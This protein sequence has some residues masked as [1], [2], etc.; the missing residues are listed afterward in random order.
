MGQIIPVILPLYVLII[1]GY[2]SVRTRYLSAVDLVGASMLIMRVFLPAMIFLAIAARP[3]TRSFRPDF[4]LAYTVAGLLA[5]MIAFGVARLAGRGTA[6]AAIEAMG[7]SCPNSGYFGLPLTTLALGSAVATQA[8]ALAVIV[9]NMIVIPV[10]IALCDLGRRPGKGGP[11]LATFALTLIRNPLL[12]AVAAGLFWA[13]TGAGL[14][15]VAARTLEMMDP[16]AA[17]AVLVAIGGALA[18]LSPAAE[19]RG[20]ARVVIGKLILHPLLALGAVAVLAPTL[21]PPLRAALVLYAASP[22]M[23]IYTLF[24]QHYREEGVAVTAM[25]GAI[26]ASVITIPAIVWLVQ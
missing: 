20:A 24:G 5:L 21:D 1:I 11:G 6:R 19:A 10:A 8:F 26:T 7:A 9:E 3:L 2:L 13:G 16:V 25:L 14:P 4:I 22:M 17:P 18:G 23:T 12:L 15:P